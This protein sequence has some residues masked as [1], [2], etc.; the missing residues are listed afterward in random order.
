[1][2]DI[3]LFCVHFAILPKINQCLREFIESWNHHSLSTEGGL[4]PEQLF[5][6]GLLQQ[7]RAARASSEDDSDDNDFNSIDLGVFSMEDTS[8]VDVPSTPDSVCSSLSAILDTISQVSDSDFGKATYIS[9]IRVV[10][11]H[12]QSGCNDCFC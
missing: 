8:I 4:T 11:T 6:L 2:N 12:I 9:A 7:S 5:T 10:G 3:D 1:M